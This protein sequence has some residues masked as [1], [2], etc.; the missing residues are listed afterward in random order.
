M[1]DEIFKLSL[2]D[3]LYR[4]KYEVDHHSHIK[5]DTTQCPNCPAKPCTFGC[6]AKVYNV[7]ANNPHIVTV[8]HENCLECGTCTKICPFDVIDWQ[9]PKGG[10]GVKYRFG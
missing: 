5:V 4:T 8:S 3:K 10:K 6:P 2:E 1:K 9:Y 7:D